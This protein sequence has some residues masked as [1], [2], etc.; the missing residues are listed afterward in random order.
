VVDWDLE[1]PPARVTAR[2]AKF[3]IDTTLAPTPPADQAAVHNQSPDASRS[4]SPP[5]AGSD[6]R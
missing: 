1:Q 5:P 6:R 4:G 2:F 3:S